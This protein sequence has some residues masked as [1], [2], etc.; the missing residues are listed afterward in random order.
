MQLD[1]TQFRYTP[2]PG[3]VPEGDYVC[4]GV[5]AA[6]MN[7]KR[8]CYGPRS[9]VMAMSG[10]SEPYDSFLCPHHNEDW[11]RQVVAL[12]REAASTASAKFGLMLELEIADI[13]HTKK[14]TKE[15][16]FRTV[17]PKSG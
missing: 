9:S 11:H 2:N 13:L 3:V 7:E 1:N 8:G 12:R 16:G 15:V 17:E 4:C 5:C 6:K 10:M 14:A